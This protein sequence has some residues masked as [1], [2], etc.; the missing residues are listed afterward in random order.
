MSEKPSKQDS[1]SIQSVERALNI[2]FMLAE[3]E[4]PLTVGQV[5]DKL[6]VH[7]STAS[8]LLSTL[9]QQNV[10]VQNRSGYQLGLGLLHLSHVVLSEMT[11]R[12]RAHP[13]LQQL[14]RETGHTVY[15]ATLFNGVELYLDEVNANDGIARPVWIG[16]TIPAHTASSGKVLLAY[17]SEAELSAYIGHGLAANTRYTITDPSQLREQLAV[18]RARGY[19]TSRDEYMIG[20]SSVAAPIFDRSGENTAVVT[21]SG[22]SSQ[23]S[24]KRLDELAPLVIATGNAISLELGYKPS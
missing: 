10:V 23:L 21:L 2:L 17:V 18:I 3:A 14:A 16:R 1:G 20:F 15:L 12:N 9:A 6:G 4:S 19:A 7:S 8:R 13:H 5:A 24:L 11:I 22:S